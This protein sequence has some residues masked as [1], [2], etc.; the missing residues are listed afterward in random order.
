MARD[1]RFWIEEELYYLYSK[2]IGA[3]QLSGYQAGDLHLCF[4]K[5]RFSCDGAEERQMA[6]IAL[7]EL[8]IDM[9][10]NS[11]RKTLICMFLL[12]IISLA[13]AFLMSTYNI[14]MCHRI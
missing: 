13:E 6:Y 12:F 14:I 2:N 4:A 9:Y 10:G 3:D 8:F 5:S 1:F 11:L 7:Y